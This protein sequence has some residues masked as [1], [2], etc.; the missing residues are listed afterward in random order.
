M[1]VFFFYL[2]LLHRIIFSTIVWFMNS[3]MWFF[4]SL[5]LGGGDWRRWFMFGQSNVGY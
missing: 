1:I 4:L 2:P 5:E 3:V